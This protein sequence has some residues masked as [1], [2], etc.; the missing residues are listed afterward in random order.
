MRALLSLLYG[1]AAYLA[2]SATFA[3]FIG[4]SAGLGVPKAID[5]GGAGLAWPEALAIDL[6]LLLMFGV[7]HLSLIHI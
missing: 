5:T 3:W 7:Q 6:V 2:F 4:F 1:L